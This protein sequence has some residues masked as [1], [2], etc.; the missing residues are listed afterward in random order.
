MIANSS[1]LATLQAEW[2]SVV[3]MHERVEHLVIS[4]FAFDTKKSPAFGDV[5]Y[6]LPLLLAFDV[7][8]QV[9]LQA[10]E[11]GLISSSQRQLSDLMDS[12]KTAL[13]WIDWQ[14]LWEGVKRQDEVAEGNQLFGDS[15]CLKY[16]AFI[17]AQLVAW[18]II[19]A[20]E[21][22][23]PR[24]FFSFRNAHLPERRKTWM[25]NLAKTPGAL[26]GA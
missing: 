5:L 12:A 18:G 23:S 3:R 1:S 4:T 9:L 7:L 6:N 20:A 17:E 2:Q 8:K 10:R 21:P 22:C 13:E 14:L 25:V 26:S 15:Q 11:E 16:I 24:S 19:M